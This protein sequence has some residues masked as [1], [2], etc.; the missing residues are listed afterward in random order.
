MDDSEDA[1]D[2]IGDVEPKDPTR[3]PTDDENEAV[4]ELPDEV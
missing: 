1:M 3:D 4:P 2:I